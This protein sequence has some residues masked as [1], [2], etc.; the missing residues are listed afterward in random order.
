[1]QLSL[2]I[3]QII[4]NSHIGDASSIVNGSNTVQILQPSSKR[5][6]DIHTD[7]YPD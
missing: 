4:V 7:I 6:S 2:T 1:M 3:R 5:T